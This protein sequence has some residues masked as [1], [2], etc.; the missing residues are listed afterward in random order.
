MGETDIEIVTGV[1]EGDELVTGSYKTLRTLKNEAR[2][3]LE[4][5]DKK[6]AGK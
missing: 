6:G 5:K 3:K 1:A 4:E 2:I